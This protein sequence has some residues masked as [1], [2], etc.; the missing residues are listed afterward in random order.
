MKPR[1]TTGQSPTPD[2]LIALIR[3]H[4]RVLA[5]NVSFGS[6]SAQDTSQNISGVWA[7]GTT[8]VTPGTLFTVNHTLGRVPVGFDVKRMDEAG[9]IYDS[10][11]PWTATQ[12]FLKSSA[13][14]ATFTLFIH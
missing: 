11:T 4:A 14:S 6:G 5:G 2:N 12:I 13:A 3:Q 7:T 10:G 8:P 9:S 1:Q